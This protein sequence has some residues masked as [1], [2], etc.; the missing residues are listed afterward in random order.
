[1]TITMRTTGRHGLLMWPCGRGHG[2]GPLGSG[3]ERLGGGGGQGGYCS[4]FFLMHKPLIILDSLVKASHTLGGGEANSINLCQFY[5]FHCNFQFR[6]FRFL[7]SIT[8]FSTPPHKLGK[9]AHYI[10]NPAQE[11][12]CKTL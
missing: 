10:Y 3:W 4:R 5:T 6:D 12:S 7:L 2:L 11:K 9:G 1:M 8:L